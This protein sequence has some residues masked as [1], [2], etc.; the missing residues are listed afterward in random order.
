ME[1]ILIE[2]IDN[3]TFISQQSVT[4]QNIYF[5]VC[6]NLKAVKFNE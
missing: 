5:E 6:N 4:E 3:Y 1:N 2:T